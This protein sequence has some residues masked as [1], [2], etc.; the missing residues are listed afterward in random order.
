VF[1]LYCLISELIITGSEPESLQQLEGFQKNPTGLFFV[2]C[3]S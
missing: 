1:A 3:Y 2:D